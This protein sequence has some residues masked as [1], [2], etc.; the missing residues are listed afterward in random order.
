MFPYHEFDNES[1]DEFLEVYEQ[2]LQ[3]LDAMNSPPQLKAEIIYIFTSHSGPLPK[4]YPVLVPLLVNPPTF[5][6]ESFPYVVHSIAKMI[7]NAPKFAF[8]IPK[9]RILELFAAKSREWDLSSSG[10]F[11]YLSLLLVLI[12]TS[13]EAFAA[14][15][16]KGFDY[17]SLS[18]C[19]ISTD[20]S[21]VTV[22]MQF[23]ELGIPGCLQ[24]LVA[25]FGNYWQL[26]DAV[27]VAAMRG[28]LEQVVAALR[29]LTRLGKHSP[30]QMIQFLN[31]DFTLTMVQLLQSGVEPIQNH[32]LAFFDEFLNTGELAL[33]KLGKWC[34]EFEDEGGRAALAQ[35]AKS[36][37]K[38]VSEHATAVAHRFED[39]EAAHRNRA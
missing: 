36:K 22:A 29:V 9:L 19:L 14:Q 12:H 2:L 21:L 24:M 25:A 26:L 31:A 34:M 32:A 35:A 10:R 4:L 11:A 5:C 7:E 6:A 17:P 38:E 30:K 16:I 23:A 13:E 18:M 28:R 33:S 8:V 20:Q 1:V 37:S 3:K 15:L 27:T 39:I